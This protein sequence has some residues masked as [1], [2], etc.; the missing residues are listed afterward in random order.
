[1]NNEEVP[2]SKK[3]KKQ[4]K[5]PSPYVWPVKV[6]I[7]SF[8]LTI[9]FSVVSELVLSGSGIAISILVI[10][11]FVAIAVISD[12]IG[13]AVTACN[14]QPFRAMASKRVR[15]AKEAIKL[16]SKADRVSSM[17]CD[18]IGDICGIL[19]GAAGATI[20]YKILENAVESQALSII[21]SAL[22]SAV[23]ASLTI[24]GKAL[25]KKY[26]MNNCTSIV[27]TVGKV[28]SLFTPQGK[29]NKDKKSEDKKDVSS[30]KQIQSSLDKIDES[31]ED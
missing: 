17:C 4:N 18:V 6:L 27:L 8:F 12:M 16:L 13:V 30:E 29:K 25:G 9:F 1:M 20:I 2:N 28:F 10:I 15:G 5:G 21:V 3:V 22:V 24:F 19:S 7:L 31:T 23:V 11:V 14:I 26:S